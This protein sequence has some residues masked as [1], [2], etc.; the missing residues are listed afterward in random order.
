MRK[1]LRQIRATGEADSIRGYAVT[2]L[3][4]SDDYARIDYCAAGFRALME[5]ICPHIDTAPLLRIEQRLA[6]GVPLEVEH[7]DASLHA[8]GC[9]KQPDQAF[10][11][12][13]QGGRDDRADTD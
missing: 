1:C 11:G 2:R 3:H 7:V 4:A 13:G 6:A 10:G 12:R 9:G 5:R 8:H